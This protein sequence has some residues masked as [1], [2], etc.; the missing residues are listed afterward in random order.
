MKRPIFSMLLVLPLV[1]GCAAPLVADLEQKE[2]LVQVSSDDGAM[3]QTANDI[4]P[5]AG[6][7]RLPATPTRPRQSPP[8]KL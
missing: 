4:A 6:P 8:R 1:S 2:V 3:R 7:L 5:A